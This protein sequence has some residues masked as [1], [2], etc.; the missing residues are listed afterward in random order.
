MA[1]VTQPGGQ[2]GAPTAG[3]NQEDKEGHIDRETWREKLK[4]G[5]GT[6]WLHDK[7]LERGADCPICKEPHFYTRKCS[8]GERSFPSNRFETCQGFKAHSNEQGC[9]KTREDAWCAYP[10]NTREGD[11]FTGREPGSLLAD[12]TVGA[13]FELL[14]APVCSQDDS[15]V[16]D[17][18]FIDGEYN[19]N[20]V[21]HAWAWW[22][23]TR[24]STF[25]WW[26]NSIGKRR[27][28][29][30]DWGWKTGSGQST[31]WKQ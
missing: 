12:S 23:P 19:M 6:K 25:E 24:A 20:F 7:L 2:A 16:T 3:A 10:G 18:V 31:G 8:W 15:K 11:I 9:W 28:W 13:M 26:T 22:G 17:I 21:T 4:T 30:S 27:S 5:E 1:E 14:H 29:C